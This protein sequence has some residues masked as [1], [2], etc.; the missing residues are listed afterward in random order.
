M[1]LTGRYITTADAAKSLGVSA[2]L[3][4]RWRSEGNGPDY[5][6]IGSVCIY[7]AADIEKLRLER[8]G[9]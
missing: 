8:E 3:L 9:K 5:I 7:R 6:K 4:R 2:A 1:D